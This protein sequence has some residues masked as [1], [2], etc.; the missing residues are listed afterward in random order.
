MNRTIDEI[1]GPDGVLARAHDDYEHHPLQIQM[2]RAVEA[3]LDERRPLVVEAATGTGKTLAYL[4][5]A[6]RSGKRVVVSTGTKA[7][8]EQLFR[9]DIPLLEEYWPDSFD[10]ALLKGRSNYLCKLRLDEVQS[11]RR[12]VRRDPNERLQTVLEWAESTETGDR[13]EIDGLPD[14]SPIWNELS[15]G[16]DECLHTDCEFYDDCFVTQAREEAEDANLLV[17]NHHLFFADLSL[18]DQGVGDILP[19]Y[20]AVVFDEAHH[21]E[22]VATSFFTTHLSNYR[23]SDL[24]GDLER[25]MREEN[26]DAPD[27]ETAIEALD[28]AGSTFFDLVSFGLGEGRYPAE[29]ALE[30]SREERLEGARVDLDEALD[31]L[32]DLIGSESAFGE[33]GHRLQE[34]CGE[35]RE[36]LDLVTARSDDDYAYVADV[37]EHG[38]FLEAAPIELDDIFRET[39]FET[40]DSLIF[41]SATL[42]T[43]GELSFFKQRLGIASDEEDEADPVDVDEMVLPPVFDYSEQSV[44][45]VPRKLPAPNTDEY[46]ENLPMLVE[47]LLDITEGR[48]FVLCTSY[49]NLHL[50][51]D[52]LADELDYPVLKQGERPKPEL[53]DEFRRETHSVL[54][55]TRSFWEGVD[56]KGDALSMVVIDKLPFANP[57]DPLVSARLDRL[58]EEGGNAFRDYSLPSAALALKQGFGRLIRSQGDVGIVAVLDSRIADK[59]YGNYFLETLPPAPVRWDAPSV[60][61]WWYRHDHTDA[62]L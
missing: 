40:H 31:D 47:Y 13:A 1:F 38:T 10:A 3:S 56:V 26:I 58:D 6:L 51:Y 23:I 37:R 17:V 49:S 25:R 15:V 41:T 52:A 29:R 28:A 20:D 55:A 27:L 33:I 44:L 19:P 42:A 2:A 18:R 59:W 30:G 60:K 39:L 32:G 8:Q 11:G 34:R 45:Y 57:S 12:S 36:A 22:R 46:E 43:G 4:V 62:E 54:F 48:A 21:L 24:I 16:P 50:L 14:D 61:R 5:P 9:K 53:L 7:L 35:L